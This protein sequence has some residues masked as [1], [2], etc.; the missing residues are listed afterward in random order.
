MRLREATRGGAG[1]SWTDAK[2]TQP[3]PP[4][5]T[6]RARRGLQH[7]NVGKSTPTALAARWQRWQSGGDITLQL[8]KLGKV[9]AT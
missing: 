3:K 7:G 4:D 5:A 6:S 1:G 9:I 2:H 8:K